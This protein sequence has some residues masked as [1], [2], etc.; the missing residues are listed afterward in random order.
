MDGI[1]FV[2]GRPVCPVC[3]ERVLRSQSHSQAVWLD[4]QIAH[5]R[6]SAG[7]MPREMAA[8]GE[9]GSS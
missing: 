7:V 6:C 3:G 8:S 9:E 4:Y 1:R 5:L 2:F